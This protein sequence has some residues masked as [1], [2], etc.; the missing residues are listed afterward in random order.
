LHIHAA[1]GTN[2]EIS[3]AVA[4]YQIRL[5]I[6]I[7]HKTCPIVYNELV[8]DSHPPKIVPSPEE[9]HVPT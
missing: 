6:T 2:I 9:I 3:I 1:V 7:A 8:A 5:R 4:I